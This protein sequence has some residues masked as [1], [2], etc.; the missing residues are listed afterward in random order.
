MLGLNFS[1]RDGKRWNTEAIA[2]QLCLC[3]PSGR[4]RIDT[5]GRKKEKPLKIKP[6]VR[7]LCDKADGQLVMLG[8]DIAAFTPASYQRHRL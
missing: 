8:F 6:E 5:L 3:R 1:V 4:Y 2:T 7:A